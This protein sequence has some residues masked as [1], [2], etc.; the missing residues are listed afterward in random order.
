MEAAAG[1]R[2]KLCVYF[3]RH[4]GP[5]FH[6]STCL[7]SANRDIGSTLSV[8]LGK[9]F[10]SCATSIVDEACFTAWA[11]AASCIC[12]LDGGGALCFP[13]WAVPASCICG[14]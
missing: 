3:F 10:A 5:G 14:V 1:G 6:W 4:A 2:K 11:V 9:G 12:V 7:G 13:A 8:G